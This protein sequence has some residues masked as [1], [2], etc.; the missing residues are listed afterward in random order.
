MERDI[1]ILIVSDSFEG[2]SWREREV[3]AVKPIRLYL[4][5]T[6]HFWFR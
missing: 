1:D 6:N 2:M 5:Y 4:L 3:R